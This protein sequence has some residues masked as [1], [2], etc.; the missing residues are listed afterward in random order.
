[1]LKI[2]VKLIKSVKSSVFLEKDCVTLC[3]ITK[4]L[5]SFSDF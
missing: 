4:Y 2:A 5:S 3:L 1:M